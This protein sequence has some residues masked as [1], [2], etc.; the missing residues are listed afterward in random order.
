MTQSLTISET[1]EGTADPVSGPP[2]VDLASQYSA[3]SWL[4]HPTTLSL[5]HNLHV[6]CPFSLIPASLATAFIS[7]FSNGCFSALRTTT[8]FL[9]TVQNHQDNR[10]WGLRAAE[11]ILLELCDMLLIVHYPLRG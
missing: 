11:S 7:I 1:Y 2:G 10:G 4:H 6:S 9:Q 8:Q 5:I 3:G